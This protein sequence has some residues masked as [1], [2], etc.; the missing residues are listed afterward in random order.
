MQQ[1]Q[2]DYRHILDAARN[3]EA[4]RLPLYE[5]IISPNKMAEITGQNF[6]PLW[7]G[8]EA[9]LR[10]Y[11]R[12]YCNFFRDHGYDTV[13]FECCTGGI[14]PGSGALGNPNHPPAIRDMA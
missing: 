8:D 14:L 11:F 2:P 12:H 5:H 13:S 9:D 7:N 1:F 3:R 4:S 10:E 6:T